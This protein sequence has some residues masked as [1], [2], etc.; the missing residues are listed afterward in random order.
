MR[1]KIVTLL[2]AGLFLAYAFMLITRTRTPHLGPPILPT[3]PEPTPASPSASALASAAPIASAPASASAAPIASASNAPSAP[4]LDRPLRVA[5]LGWELAA[6]TIFANGG[7]DA[8]STG[9]F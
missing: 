5:A 7:L 1:S 8:A 6:P 3:V 9:D 2:L 4:L